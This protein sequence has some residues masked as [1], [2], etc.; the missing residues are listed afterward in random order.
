[1][2]VRGFNEDKWRAAGGG[3]YDTREEALRAESVRNNNGPNFQY[4]ALNAIGKLFC[5]IPH[6]L[7][8]VTGAVCGLILK[9]GIVGKVILTALVALFVFIILVLPLEELGATRHAVWGIV[10]VVIELGG[11]IAAGAWF[12]LRHYD[13]VKQMP[14]RNFV[15]L[16]TLCMV[17]CFWGTIVLLIANSLWKWG[18]GY[19]GSMIIPLVAAIVLWLIKANEYKSVSVD[20]IPTPVPAADKRNA[21]GD[22]VWA[23]WSGD[24]NLYFANIVS[25]GVS[26]VKVVFYDGVTEEVAPENVFYI[27]EVQKSGLAPHGNWQDKGS[28]YPCI[29]LQFNNNTVSVEYIEDKVQEQLPYHGLVFMK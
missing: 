18:I 27:E 20:Y 11:A 28:F 19:S 29:I 6:L 5:L 25:G 15:S 4:E 14:Y 8:M 13:V 3:E 17:I 22:L 10:S 12:W 16:T 26:G 9:L 21:P 23:R 24:G 7:G 2:A 1:M